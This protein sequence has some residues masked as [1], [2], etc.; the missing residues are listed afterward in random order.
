MDWD[1]DQGWGCQSRDIHSGYLVRARATT[2]QRGQCSECVPARGTAYLRAYCSHGPRQHGVAVLGVPVPRLLEACVGSCAAV[3]S[4]RDQKPS[5]STS[6]LDP[7]RPGAATLLYHSS[8]T[9]LY[10][11]QA[12]LEANTTE[13]SRG[14]GST[15]L[16]IRHK[17]TDH[18]YKLPV[19]SHSISTQRGAKG[20]AGRSLC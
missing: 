8:P 10:G 18:A 4:R 6:T 19:C 13:K 12:R 14:R 15:K 2:G 3:P 5:T 9:I 1:C 11:H 16:S 20:N 7:H 17:D